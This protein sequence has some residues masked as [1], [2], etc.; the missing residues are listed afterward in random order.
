[1]SRRTKKFSSGTFSDIQAEKQFKKKHEDLRDDLS[2]DIVDEVG[3]VISESIIEEIEN[4]GSQ[5]SSDTF[6]EYKNRQYKL[7][8]T[9]KPLLA[10]Y[11]ADIEKAITRKKE[12]KENLLTS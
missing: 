5:A 4:S 7:A 6:E 1:M 11:I 10:T 12:Q 2:D 3:S 8:Q 9:S